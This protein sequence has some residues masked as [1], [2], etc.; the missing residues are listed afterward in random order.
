MM[1]YKIHNC[2]LT[3][4]ILISFL[5]KIISFPDLKMLNQLLQIKVHSLNYLF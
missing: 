3:F 4:C 5:L 2:N 1:S